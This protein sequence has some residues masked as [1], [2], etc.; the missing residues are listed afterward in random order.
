MDDLEARDL[1]ALRVVVFGGEV[2]PAPPLRTLRRRLPHPRYFNC[3]GS[4]ETNIATYYELPAAAEF[5]A[6]PP[7]RPSV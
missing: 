1:T 5:D 7:D 2:F 6:P 4:T 3:W